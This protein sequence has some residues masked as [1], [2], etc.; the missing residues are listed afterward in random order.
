MFWKQKKQ[1]LIYPENIKDF[2]IYQ[3]AVKENFDSVINDKNQKGVYKSDINTYNTTLTSCNC[4]YFDVNNTPCKHMY[5]LAIELGI[6]NKDYKLT[7][8]TGDYKKKLKA[9]TNTYVVVD[10]KMAG[11]YYETDEIIEIGAIKVKEQEIISVFST[12][13]KT[14]KVDETILVSNNITFKMMS[15]APTIQKAIIDFKNFIEEYPLVIYDA[16]LK[17]K[18]LGKAMFDV[19]EDLDNP[20]VDIL[21]LAKKEYLLENYKLMTLINHLKSDTDAPV[22]HTSIDNCY[23][24][25]YIYSDLYQKNLLKEP[26]SPGPNTT[27]EELEAFKILSSML[28]NIIGTERLTYKDTGSY[29]AVL[30]N[31]NPRKW[32][33]RLKL[34]KKRKILILPTENKQEEQYILNDLQDLLKY[35]HPMVEIVQKL[36]I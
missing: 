21:S 15:N 34:G 14:T 25:N 32:I 7:N 18:F 22:T 10:L 8:Y 23:L 13:I 27:Q 17:A 12:L 35:Y 26:S 9:N 3:S 36:I 24:V 11:S 20:F 29:F 2:K 1:L 33:C 19:S 6:L 31:D 4:A 28:T 30:I 16:P 5:N